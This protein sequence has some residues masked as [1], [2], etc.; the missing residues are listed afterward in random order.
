MRYFLTISV[1]VSVAV[2]V[3]IV[4]CFVLMPVLNLEA[5]SFLYLVGT[6]VAPTY[7]IYDW[8]TGY[9][10]D[11]AGGAQS[12]FNTTTEIADT[13][14]QIGTSSHIW[15][16]DDIGLTRSHKYI[17]QWFDSGSTSPDMLEEYIQ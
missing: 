2:S 6:T 8:D 7:T 5:R 4:V 13:A 12:D 3:A 1:A 9:F 14:T 17:I 10:Y 11:G 15:S 16:T